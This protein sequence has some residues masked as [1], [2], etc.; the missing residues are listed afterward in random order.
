MQ[1]QRTLKSASYSG[2]AVTRTF[3]VTLTQ[4]LPSHFSQAGLPAIF[5]AG[6]AA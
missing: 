4:P 6:R 3:L 1:V 5:L 2:I